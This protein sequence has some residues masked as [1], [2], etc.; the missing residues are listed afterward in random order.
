MNTI[1]VM[2][3]DE[4]FDFGSLL[5]FYNI[6]KVN[7]SDV[8]EVIRKCNPIAFID[9]VGDVDLL[10]DI[11]K[12][13]H[14]RSGIIV[15]RES[16]ESGIIAEYLGVGVLYT[17]VA[18]FTGAE[19]LRKVENLI[20]LLTINESVISSKNITTIQLE[21]LEKSHSRLKRILKEA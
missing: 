3:E 2:E 14:K 20:D 6:E 21:Q 12:A 7:T 10:C 16:L 9:C 15:V 5:A 19:V 8:F 18:P 11:R 1:I 17:I 4:K 13:L